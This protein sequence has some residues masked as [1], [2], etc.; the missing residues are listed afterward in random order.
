MKSN[1]PFAALSKPELMILRQC[2][3]S[4]NA[5]T[6]Q[7]MISLAVPAKIRFIA[8]SHD[9]ITATLD[10]IQKIVK[11]ELDDFLAERNADDT[12]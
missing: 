8:Y 10:K 9:F 12:A 1:N 3:F 11:A 7:V 6:K 2:K 4:F 5:D